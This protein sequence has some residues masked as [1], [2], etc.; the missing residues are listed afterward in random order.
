[1]I[2]RNG[3]IMLVPGQSPVAAASVNI[4]ARAEQRGAVIVLVLDQFSAGTAAIPTVSGG[5][6]AKATRDPEIYA[7]VLKAAHRA[8]F[9]G[10]SDAR[11]LVGA[12][13]ADMASA[14][15]LLAEH[16]ALNWR[17]ECFSKPHVALIDGL[18]GGAGAGISL[19]GTHRVAGAAYRFA[20]PETSTGLVPGHGVMHGFAR[21]PK[22]VG[23]YLA[24][25]GRSIGRADALALGLVTHCVAAD[26][27]ADIEARLSRAEPVDPILDGLHAD[28]GDGEL[29]GL[30]DVI[31]RCFG[32]GT[33]SAI[34]ER[35]AAERGAHHVWARGVVQDLETRSPAALAA[36]LRHLWAATAM[37]LRQTLM[38]DYRLAVRAVERRD[39]LEGAGSPLVDTAQPPRWVPGRVA[40]VTAV[41][42]DQLFQPD[43]ED[44]FILPTR[45]EMQAARS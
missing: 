36:T 35:L 17:L 23:A 8:A 13:R 11:A 42:I 41:T 31:G 15:R 22:G 27:F 19:Y 24:L 45:Q 37:D 6:L 21:M 40:D 25:T 16:Y 3:G 2:A 14:R 32:G 20:T 1:M 29:A 12:V 7:V 34:I 10:G 4:G 30:A 9:C 33:V 26:A 44:L 18:V 43:T 28:P 5:V 39:F 38:M